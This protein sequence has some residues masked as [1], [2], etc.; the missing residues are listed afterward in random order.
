MGGRGQKRRS[1]TRAAPAALRLAQEAPGCGGS[2]SRFSS[3]FRRERRGWLCRGTLGSGCRRSWPGAPHQVRSTRSSLAL[4]TAGRPCWCV[5]LGG[6]GSTEGF[7]CGRGGCWRVTATAQV[8]ASSAEPPSGR[9]KRCDCAEST[10]DSAHRKCETCIVA[11]RAC[12]Q[13]IAVHRPQQPAATLKSLGM[14]VLER[15]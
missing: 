13:M 6:A 8:A 2:S 5:W 7:R 4:R 1:A 11:G 3:A 15:C 12:G 9:Q 10:D 14:K